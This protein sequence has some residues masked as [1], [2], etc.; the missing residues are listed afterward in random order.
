LSSGSYQFAVV[1][2]AFRLSGFCARPDYVA[3][4]PARSGNRAWTPET[5]HITQPVGKHSTSSN[6][7]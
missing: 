5:G 4:A 7:G 1:T 3:G 6:Y 2:P